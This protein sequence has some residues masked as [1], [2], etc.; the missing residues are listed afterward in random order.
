MRALRIA[1]VFLYLCAAVR[2]AAAAE[3]AA[4]RAGEE[5]S[6]ENIIGFTRALISKREFYRASIELQRLQTF[7][8]GFVP[9][10]QFRIT[11][12]YLMYRGGA[13]DGI[14]ANP[15]AGKDARVRCID[16]LFR[17]DVYLARYEFGAARELLGTGCLGEDGDLDTMCRK[18]RFMAVQL[19]GGEEPLNRWTSGAQEG[20][21]SIAWDD[22]ARYAISARD[23][24][25]SPAAAL[26]WGVL[27]GMG[28]TYSGN[29]PTGILACV[30]ISL[31][32]GLTYLSFKTDNQPL[33]I[34]FGFAAT[35][36]Y[37]GSVIGGYR[38]ALRANLAIREQAAA[39]FSEDLRLERDRERLLAD[40]GIGDGK[41]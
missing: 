18:R 30:V 17:A 27:P 26:G 29:R 11:G 24:E 38:E 3:N 2:G 34:L 35:A 40:Y 20:A 33:G 31:V 28:Y 16:S 36:F 23:R 10:T 6:P 12:L 9:D 1:C 32:A 7:H 14:L 4:P 5:Y 19:G 21:G 37:G 41:K 15:Y 25:K 22:L 13:L 39:R 8:P